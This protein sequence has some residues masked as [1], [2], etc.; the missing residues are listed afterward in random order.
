MLLFMVQFYI[1]LAVSHCLCLSP[2]SCSL[3]VVVLAHFDLGTYKN[4]REAGQSSHLELSVI[5]Y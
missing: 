1:S 5:A 4:R 2:A 3:S